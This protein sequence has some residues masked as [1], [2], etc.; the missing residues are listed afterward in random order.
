MLEHVFGHFPQPADQLQL[1]ASRQERVERG[2]LG[3]VSQPAPVSDRVIADAAS[4]E[5]HHARRWFHQPRHHPA[6]GGLARS[7][8]SQVPDHF[9]GTDDE[10]DIVDHLD[11]VKAFDQMACFEQWSGHGT[12]K[13]GRTEQSAGLG[14]RIQAHQDGWSGGQLRST[15]SA[16]ILVSSVSDTPA[17]SR[18]RVLHSAARCDPAEGHRRRPRC[19]RTASPHLLRQAA[20]RIARRTAALDP[21]DR[22]HV[23]VAARSC[24]SAQRVGRP[25]RPE[26]ERTA[27]ARDRAS[28]RR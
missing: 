14:D 5:Q 6:G 22:V 27:V 12:P 9:T 10:T 16:S 3:N 17:R 28:A 11:A 18:M 7:V 24:A 21:P 19:R 23:R 2:L 13:S 20:D 4:L 1:L 8:R 26:E 15:P 25:V